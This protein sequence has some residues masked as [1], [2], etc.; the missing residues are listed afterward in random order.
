MKKLFILLI[1]NFITLNGYS[2][3]CDDKPSIKE[4]WEL[5]DQVFIGKIIKVDSLL[6]GNYGEKVYSFTVKITKLYKGE[7]FKDREFRTILAVSSGQCDSFF[8]V[9]EEYLIYAKDN[10][11]TL[12]C[13]ICSRTGLLSN[14]DSDELVLLDKINQE[15]I[16]N[17]GQ[18]R[19]KKIQNSIQYQL[20]LVKESFEE[21]LKGK[22]QIIYVLSVLGFLLFV[23]IIFL[24]NR[25]KKV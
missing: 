21:K 23:I 10:N 2:C 5:A 19:V 24:I 1:I 6:Y 18:I 20:A 4:N 12:S 17:A 3:D 8:Y 11:Y 7:I 13:S 22:D 9:G 16:K 14:I 25:N 15:S